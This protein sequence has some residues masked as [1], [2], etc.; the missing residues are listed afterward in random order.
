M[1]EPLWDTSTVSLPYASNAIFI[2][3]YT[4]KLLG[5]SFPNMTTNEVSNLKELVHNAHTTCVL[6]FLIFKNFKKIS[7]QKK[8]I[9]NKKK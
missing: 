5:S 4:I 6:I 7:R 2:R 1:T 3:E 8:N 9:N